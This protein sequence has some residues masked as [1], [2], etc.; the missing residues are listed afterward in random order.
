MRKQIVFAVIILSLITTVIVVSRKNKLI[1]QGQDGINPL[2]ESQD[3]G[4][5]PSRYEL[6]GGQLQSAGKQYQ[7]GLVKTDENITVSDISIPCFKQDETAGGVKGEFA[8]DLRRE[9]NTPFIDSLPLGKLEF[10]YAPGIEQDGHFTMQTLSQDPLYTAF[11]LAFRLSCIQTQIRMFGV[12]P[13]GDTLIEYKFYTK[14]NS[15]IKLLIPV[16]KRI[17]QQDEVLHVIRD[18]YNEKTGLWDK[19][20][21]A[22]D[23]KLLQFTEI[24]SWSQK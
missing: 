21:F 12:D 24:E 14:N 6:T 1:Q 18:V 15:E 2:P 10:S 13:V 23:S 3:Y 9:L 5:N 8:L 19:T 20:R 22:F 4:N 7:V 16:G 17:P 11:S